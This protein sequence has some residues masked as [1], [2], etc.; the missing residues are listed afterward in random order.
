MCSPLHSTDR[1]WVHQDVSKVTEWLLLLIKT[2]NSFCNRQ[3][4]SWNCYCLWWNAL[5]LLR[6]PKCEEAHD[7]AASDTKSAKSLSHHAA[8]LGEHITLTRAAANAWLTLLFSITSCC[9]DRGNKNHNPL[10]MRVKSYPILPYGVSDCR[11]LKQIPPPPSSESISINNN[12][13]ILLF[14]CRR[15]SLRILE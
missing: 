8:N 2:A 7:Y 13:I 4:T 6:V 5:L 15:I 11:S 9:C 10:S 12:N 1:L 3:N 14:I